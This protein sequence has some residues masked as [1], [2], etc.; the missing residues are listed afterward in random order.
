MVLVIS[1][2]RLKDWMVSQA[3]RNVSHFS[4]IYRLHLFI[5]QKTS[6]KYPS[7]S[8]QLVCQLFFRRKWCSMKKWLVWLAIQTIAQVFFL[9]KIILTCSRNTLYIFPVWLHY[10]INNTVKLGFSKI[11]VFYFHSRIL[12]WDI[13]KNTWCR[14]LSDH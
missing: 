14:E 11:I 6:A 5:S 10:F 12:K 8:I 2:S 1:F 3:T 4:W 13:L 9:K 7:L